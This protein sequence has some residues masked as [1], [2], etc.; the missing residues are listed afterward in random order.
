MSYI[1]SSKTYQAY[2]CLLFIF[3]APYL[4]LLIFMTSSIVLTSI[5]LFFFCLDVFDTTSFLSPPLLTNNSGFIDH[6]FISYRVL[7]IPVGNL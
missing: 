2:K 1:K 4:N 5:C 3:F 7:L 6:N